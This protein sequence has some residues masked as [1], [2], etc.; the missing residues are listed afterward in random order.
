M[1]LQKLYEG[2]SILITADDLKNHVLMEISSSG[3]RPRYVS[4]Y[5]ES[6]KEIDDLIEA[7]N[8]AKSYLKN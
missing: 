7:L 6:Q 8:K 1:S 5:I 2:D 4:M 3:Y